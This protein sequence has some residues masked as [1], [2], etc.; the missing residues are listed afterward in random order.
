MGW[1]VGCAV[2]FT[3]SETIMRVTLLAITMF[4][5]KAILE[6]LVVVLMEVL[7]GIFMVVIIMAITVIFT[8][9]TIPKTFG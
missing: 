8:M 6:V 9:T 2:Y 1:L 3:R 7:V 5:V 4:F